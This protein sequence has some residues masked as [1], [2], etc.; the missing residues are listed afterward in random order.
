VL[1][2][3]AQS[4]CTRVYTVVV[5]LLPLIA[6]QI[7]LFVQVHKSI[8]SRGENKA[9][10]RRNSLTE[11][12]IERNVLRASNWPNSRRKARSD[13]LDSLCNTGWWEEAVTLADL[14]SGNEAGEGEGSLAGAAGGLDRQACERATQTVCDEAAMAPV[15]FLRSK[16]GMAAAE[17]ASTLDDF[18]ER[19]KTQLSLVVERVANRELRGLGVQEPALI[20]RWVREAVEVSGFL[21]SFLI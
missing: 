5:A 2:A 18:L 4:G 8:L 11:A 14:G 17:E 12:I 7:F 20:K 13:F 6:F 10:W 19:G 16:Q 3:T 1:A 15:L 21:G 9:W